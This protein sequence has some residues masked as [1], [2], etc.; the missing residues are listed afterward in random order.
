MGYINYVHIYIFG[1]Q[2]PVLKKR[3]K[4][5]AYCIFSKMQTLES[6]FAMCIYIYNYI[7]NYVYT[8]KCVYGCFLKQR[9][10]RKKGLW[11]WSEVQPS[12]PSLQLQ[13]F[14]PIQAAGTRSP[15]LQTQSSAFPSA[16]SAAK[17]GGKKVTHPCGKNIQGAI[18]PQWPHVTLVSGV[19]STWQVQVVLWQ[20]L[21]GVQT[22]RA[23]NKP[24]LI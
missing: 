13:R 1:L 17:Y 20:R 18:G 4:H 3:A 15:Q 6:N 5:I 23:R 8:C 9:Y 24:W 19:K 14:Q 10:P 11:D 7:Y 16:D 2:S 22:N 21:H 12:R